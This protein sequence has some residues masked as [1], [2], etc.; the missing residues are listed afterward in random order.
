M[1]SSPFFKPIVFFGRYIDDVLIIWRGSVEDVEAFTSYC[2][3]NEFGLKFTHVIDP[4][5][6]F[7]L[8]LE[9]IYDEGTIVTRDFC[10]SVG[11][12]LY[13]LYMSYIT[14]LGGTIF[15]LANFIG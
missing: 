8:D 1:L 14:P 6:Q 7:F 10:K 15:L 12:N 13:L 3:H 4:K 9:L 5:S 11:G 2:N